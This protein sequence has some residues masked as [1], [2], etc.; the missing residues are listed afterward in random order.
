MDAKYHGKGAVNK[1]N[2]TEV[3]RFSH[4]YHL[5]ASRVVVPWPG[6]A[7]GPFKRQQ[8]DVSVNI[9]LH[10]NSLKKKNCHLI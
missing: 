10:I 6:T 8:N 4:L 5:W 1:E 9:S 2:S 7:F 3:G